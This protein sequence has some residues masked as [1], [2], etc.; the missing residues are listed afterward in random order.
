MQDKKADEQIES[1]VDEI[2]EV[3]LHDLDI[4]S[5]VDHDERSIAPLVWYDTQMNPTQ[6]ARLYHLVKGLLSAPGIW[7]NRRKYAEKKKRNK[8]TPT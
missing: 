7:T 4:T 5:H 2:V 3:V 8:E 6:R 1:I